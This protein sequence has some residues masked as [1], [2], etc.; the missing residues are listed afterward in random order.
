[1]WDIIWVECFVDMVMDWL[2]VETIA[3]T[4]YS[5]GILVNVR[6]YIIMVDDLFIK[7]E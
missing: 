6:S 3:G 1:M 2:I 4:L 7:W 5:G